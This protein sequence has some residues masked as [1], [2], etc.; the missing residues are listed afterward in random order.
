MKYLK[1]F[2]NFVVIGDKVISQNELNYILKG[3]LD[4]A[5]WTEE[6]RL[7][8]EQ[9]TNKLNIDFNEDDTDD[10]MDDFEKMY[11]R[12]NTSKQFTI[13]DIETNSLISTYNDIKEFIRNAGSNAINYAIKENG[14]ERLGHDIWLTRNGHGAGFFD[15]NYDDDIQT[16]L[17]EAGKNLKEKHLYVTEENQLM[18]E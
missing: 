5:L 18:F 11:K 12:K 8:D 6:D 15:H 14:Y 4:C 9:E 3:Y 1:Y 16:K 2:E 17:I 7:K 13:E 10:E